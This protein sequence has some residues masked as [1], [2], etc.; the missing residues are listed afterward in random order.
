M[1]HF[2]PDMTFAALSKRADE[3]VLMDDMATHFGGDD[4]RH[5]TVFLSHEQIGWHEGWKTIGKEVM[6]VAV[7]N[8]DDPHAEIEIMNRDEA[9][10]FFGIGVVQEWEVME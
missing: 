5:I 6:A 10:A 8:L 3:T 4:Q 2:T 1:K 9:V 7:C